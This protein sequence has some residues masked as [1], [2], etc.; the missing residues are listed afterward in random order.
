[1]L[2]NSHDQTIKVKTENLNQVPPENNTIGLKYDIWCLGRLLYNLC[3]ASLPNRGQINFESLTD[4]GF[5][6][7]LNDLYLRYL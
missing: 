7:E 5:S 2:L 3:L 1:L 6:R 4:M